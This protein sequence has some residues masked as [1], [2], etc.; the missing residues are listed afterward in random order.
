MDDHGVCQAAR[1]AMFGV[2]GTPIRLRGAEALI[3]GQFVD[4]GLLNAVAHLVS[5]NLEPDSDIHASA[6]YRKE[7]GGVVALRTLAAALGVAKR[8][9]GAR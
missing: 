7:V 9:G 3:S 2:G 1:L 5:E 4:E 8:N 6:E